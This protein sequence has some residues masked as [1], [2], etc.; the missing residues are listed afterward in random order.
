[1]Q[2]NGMPCMIEDTEMKKIAIETGS[3]SNNSM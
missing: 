1:M 3:Q 2:T